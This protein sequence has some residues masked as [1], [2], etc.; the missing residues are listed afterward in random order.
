MATPPSVKKILPRGDEV[1][2]NP[3]W[4]PVVS[5]RLV[6]D[7]G[8]WLMQRRPPNKAHGG[9]WEFPG[10]KVEQDET[11]LAALLRELDEELGIGV[12]GADCRPLAFAQDE[13]ANGGLPIVLFLYTVAR[14]SRTPEAREGAV[15]GWFDHNEARALAMPPLD[16]DLLK[17]L[18]GVSPD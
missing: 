2:K 11:P 9:L 3:T 18:R 8:R 14:W 13:G 10:G 12:A 4:L 6:R 7:D 16:R 5:A 17:R 1:E 15:L